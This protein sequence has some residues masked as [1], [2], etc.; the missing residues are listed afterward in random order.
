VILA[1]DDDPDV[2]ERIV[3]ALKESKRGAEERTL[4]VD[5]IEPPL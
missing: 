3:E 1:V 5:G 2:I 4:R